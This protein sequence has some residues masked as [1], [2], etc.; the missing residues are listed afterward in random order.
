MEENNEFKN[1]ENVENP[2]NVA[3]NNNQPQKSP[4][5]KKIIAGVA[6]VVV[7]AGVITGVALSRTKLFTKNDSSNNNTT[8]SN[9][10]TEQNN[11]IETKT[12]QKIDESKPWVYDADYGKDNE[13]KKLKPQYSNEVYSTID[14]LRIPYININSDDA[15]NVNNELKNLYDELYN[16]FGK[17]G[18]TVM[19]SSYTVYNNSNILS[20][21]IRIDSGVLNG[22][23][24]HKY[25]TYNFNL[26]TLKKADMFEVA[27]KCGFKSK[28]D[29]NKAIDNSLLKAKKELNASENATRNDDIYYITNYGGFGTMVLSM[30]ELGY[31]E[32]IVETSMIDLESN[33]V[34]SNQTTTNTTDLS[35]FKNLFYKNSGIK[36]NIEGAY[37]VYELYFDKDAKPTIKVS[38]K[39]SEQTE[40]YFITQDVKNLKTDVAAGTVYVHFDFTAWTPG[41]DTTGS[42][43]IRYSSV[44]NNSTL[45][46][47]ATVNINGNPIVYNDNGNFVEVTKLDVTGY[48]FKDEFT[49]NAKEITLYGKDFSS[50]PG[51]NAR[52][53]I[54][55]INENNELCK[56]Y[57]ING[58][59]AT[60]ILAKNVKSIKANMS[61]VKLHIYPMASNFYTDDIYMEDECTYFENIYFDPD[62]F[63]SA[64][65]KGDIIKITNQDSHCFTVKFN[66]AY[67]P[68][69]GYNRKIEGTATITEAGTYCYVDY[70]LGKEYKLNI[71]FINDKEIEM[72]EY[73]DGNLTATEHLFK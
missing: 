71:K 18:E 64:N 51:T 60:D 53:R 46:V 63:Y 27:Q 16:A 67:G 31:V 66:H 14:M 43:T 10:S 33:V 25:K 47:T 70:S 4:K 20:I 6:C 2:N 52:N 62:A 54:Y 57:S 72:E 49:D 42:G 40:A 68:T 41:G 34:S 36:T 19:E 9:N 35:Q 8:S 21:V 59:Y 1:P 50:F 38:S 55:Y 69:Q 12:T 48:T 3:S 45:G 65:N 24:T 26:E 56:T 29:L 17:N 22:G 39:S 58:G 5:A 7:V 28:E 13:E 44:S 23:K 73:Y 15:K 11:T 61:E 30:S 32:L 37:N